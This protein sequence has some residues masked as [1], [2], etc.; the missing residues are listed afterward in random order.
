M[1]IAEADPI[2]RISARVS[3]PEA[4]GVNQPPWEKV[5]TDL[6]AE[7]RSLRISRTMC[8]LTTAS[9]MLRASH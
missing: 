5:I 7:L 1:N 6:G 4:A 3:S 9:A 8:G 2:M